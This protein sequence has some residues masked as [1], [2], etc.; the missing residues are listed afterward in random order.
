M[1]GYD[2]VHRVERSKAHQ[3]CTL[4]LRLYFL[5]ATAV[6]TAG[7]DGDFVR[8]LPSKTSDGV[9]AE[10]FEDTMRARLG[11]ELTLLTV[12]MCWSAN[13]ILYDT[14]L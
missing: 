10:D 13:P 7:H 8:I 6:A 5:Y 2:Y 9:D 3:N 1:C 4:S 12:V 14:L 11:R